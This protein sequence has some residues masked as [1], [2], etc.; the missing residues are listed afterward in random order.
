LTDVV[1]STGQFEVHPSVVFKLGADLITDDIQA[2]AELVK[3]AYD[4]DAKT[5]I[6]RIDTT[7]SHEEAPEDVGFIDIVDTGTG[8]TLENIRR[9]WLTISSSPKREFKA[10][11][12]RTGLKRTPLGDKGLGRLGSQRLGNRVTIITTPSGGGETHRLSFDWR[13]FESYDSLSQMTVEI[14]SWP[15]KLKQGTRIIVSGLRR[16][17]TLNKDRLAEELSRTISPYEGVANFRL[18]VVLDDEP[19]DLGEAATSVRNGAVIRYSLNF[20]GRKLTVR[21][22]IRLALFKPTAKKDHPAFTKFITADKGASLLKHL[23]S[24]PRAKDFVLTRSTEPGWWGEVRAEFDLSD[25]AEVEREHSANGE[26]GRLATPGPF[27]SEIDAFNLS[28]GSVQEIGAFDS[29]SEARSALRSFAGVRVYRDGFNVRVDD[30]WLGLGRQWT[31]GK[32]FFGLRPATTMGYVAISAAKNQQL[33]ETTDREGFQGTPHYNNMVRLLDRFVLMTADLQQF[34]GREGAAFRDRAHVVTDEERDPSELVEDLGHLLGQAEAWVGPLSEVRIA[35]EEHSRDA[36]ALVTTFSARADLSNNEMEMLASLNA[37]SRYA[38]R[39]TELV[40]ELSRFVT[41]VAEQQAVGARLQL[42]MDQLNEQLSLAY[43]TIAVGLTAEALSHEIAQIA[44]RLARRAATVDR[45]IRKNAPGDRQ[46]GRFV[47]EVIGSVAGLRRQL[48][49][50]APSLRFVR[51]RRENLPLSEVAEE[52]ASYFEDRWKNEPISIEFQL[53]EDFAVLMN[54]G[55]LLQVFDNLVL[56]SEY[57]LGESI[58]QGELDRGLVTIE[59]DAPL[60]RIFDNGR[61]IE[62]GVQ[63][64]LFEAFVSRK[65]RGAGRGLGLFIVRQLLDAEGS[66][67]MLL[68]DHNSHGRPYTFEIDLSGAVAK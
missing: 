27:H 67:I 6:V 17:E 63:H 36:E 35:L 68:P 15:S 46:L 29:V 48:A 26:R 24:N 13:D 51:E 52:V 8:M 2:I 3:N 23:Q 65:P 33:V 49:H 21:S 32:S 57:W 20:D 1:H 62:P 50:L 16:P 37:L 64:S 18:S 28:A 44:T 11:G 59:I 43:D 10:A 4:A 14:G 66:S 42:E 5:V 56:N 34:L 7:R 40:E 41:E 31:T 22:L 39:A 12:K 25:V 58:R 53:R 38:R 9:G 54:R 30:D 47:E 45:H 61:G 55:K 60:V 19:I